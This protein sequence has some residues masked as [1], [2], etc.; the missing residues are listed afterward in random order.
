VHGHA[1]LD[2]HADR[3]DLALGPAVV[4]GQPDAGASLHPTGAREAH[5][6]DHGDQRLLE[7]ADVLDDVQR[8]RE[9]HEGVADE[10]TGTVPGDEAAAV[11]IDDGGAVR[12]PVRRAGPLA[13]GIDRRVLEKHEDVRTGAVAPGGGVRALGVPGRA[14]LDEAE[15][16]DGQRPRGCPAGSRAVVP[17]TDHATPYR[18]TKH[19]VPERSTRA[20]PGLVERACTRRGTQSSSALVTISTS[21][22]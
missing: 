16:F 14:V 15:L 2:P 18:S 13:R 3:G 4:R 1:A 21:G 9:R 19:G 7:T 10:L 12:G 17:H 8:N 20:H 6:G 11:D 22:A 5:V